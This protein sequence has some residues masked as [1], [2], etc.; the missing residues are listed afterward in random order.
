MQDGC[1]HACT[2]CIT[3][4]LRGPARSRPLDDAVQAARDLVGQGAQ[5]IVLTGVSLGA[6]GHDLGLMAG[7]A[8]LVEAI[9][10]TTDVPRL[11]LSSV[12]PWDVDEAL[13]RQWANPRLCRQ[14]H[15]P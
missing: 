15:L 6:Y 3:R 13:L 14:L 12:E 2:Y 9:L 10:L 4:L 7:L 1:D 8:T 11:R 5:E